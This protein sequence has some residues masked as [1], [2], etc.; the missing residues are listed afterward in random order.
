LQA[1]T[2]I[3]TRDAVKDVI[4]W[5]QKTFQPRNPSLAKLPK[6]IVSV[7]ILP[8]YHS[9]KK[10]QTSS[11]HTYFWI[12]SQ[13]YISASASHIC[14]NG[15]GMFSSCLGNNFSFPCGILM[16]NIMKQTGEKITLKQ[17]P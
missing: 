3:E 17:M 15:Y 14:R 16:D 2:Y 9:V 8:T 12:S 6:I 5:N 11:M 7:K 1:S 13:N 10:R 4:H